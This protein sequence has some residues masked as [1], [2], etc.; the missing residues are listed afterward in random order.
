MIH[1]IDVVIHRRAETHFELWVLRSFA[2]ALAEW[3]LDAGIEDEI[4]FAAT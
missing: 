2:E 1:H 4:G 3:L